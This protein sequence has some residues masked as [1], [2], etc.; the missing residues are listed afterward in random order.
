M[1]CRYV[2]VIHPSGDQFGV[3]IQSGSPAAG[4]PADSR[5]LVPAAPDSGPACPT[6]LSP[7]KNL[8]LC[9]RPPLN[10]EQLQPEFP[11]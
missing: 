7:P 4:H 3:Q 11:V 6:P 10:A 1:I 5:N 2:G 8:L 9:G